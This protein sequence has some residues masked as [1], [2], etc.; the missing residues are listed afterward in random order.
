MNEPNSK[1]P[2]RRVLQLIVAAALVLGVGVPAYT[3]YQSAIRHAQASAHLA[4]LSEVR[5]QLDRHHHD[6]GFYP[7]K[8]S[9]L[10]ITNFPD[11]ATPTMLQQFRYESD[12]TTYTLHYFRVASR[13]DIVLRPTA[14]PANE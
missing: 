3:T 1:R 4:L 5:T 10:H 14:Q 9:Q 13:R 11:G 7:P 2:I 6:H 12:G 8:L